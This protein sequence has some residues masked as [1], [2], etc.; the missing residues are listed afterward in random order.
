[1]RG[2]GGP[3]PIAVALV[4]ALTLATVVA[5]VAGQ[6]LRRDGT[7]FSGTRVINCARTEFEGDKTCSAGKPVKPGDSALAICFK[8]GVDD[9]VRA[10]LLGED[11]KRVRVLAPEARVRTDRRKCLHWDGRDDEGAPLPEGT[12]RL[13]LSYAETDRVA[14]AGEPVKLPRRRAEG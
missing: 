6:A 9:T 13:Q 1:M 11:G 12:Y 8:P 7:V 5:V 3:G 10:E 2:R 4:A 14:V